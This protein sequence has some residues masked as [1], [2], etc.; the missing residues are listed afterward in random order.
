LLINVG[1]QAINKRTKGVMRPTEIYLDFQKA[2]SDSFTNV[3]PS[4]TVA[5]DLFH[6]IQA[7]VKKMG[8]LGYGSSVS[9]LVKDLN[10]L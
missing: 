4:A 3:F 10:M 1:M 8:K 9:D 6:F 5:R 7:N 2:L